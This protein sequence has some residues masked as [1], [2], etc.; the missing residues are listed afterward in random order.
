MA[1]SVL[2]PV[3]ARL[4]GTTTP[5]RFLGLSDHG[6]TS[7]VVVRRAGN[8][9]EGPWQNRPWR[10]FQLDSMAT[11][12][13]N[14]FILKVGGRYWGVS[15]SGELVYYTDLS[16]RFAPPTEKPIHPEDWGSRLGRVNIGGAN[17]LHRSV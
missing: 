14:D 9:E 16:R 11:R 17:L 6:P 1:T 4:H 10:Q 13:Q 2:A 7:W 15:T 8:R 5:K 12:R 3:G